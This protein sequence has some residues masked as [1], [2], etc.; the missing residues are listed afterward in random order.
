MTFLFIY[1]SLSNLKQKC[2]TKLLFI[3]MKTNTILTFTTKNAIIFYKE[4]F[5]LVHTFSS[6]TLKYTVIKK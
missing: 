5:C 4:H 1:F 2:Y 6:K 3:P